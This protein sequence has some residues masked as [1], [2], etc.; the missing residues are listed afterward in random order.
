MQRKQGFTLI[1]LLVVISIIALLIG[2]LLP[3][4]G[5]ARRTA[6][7][8][9]NNT[10]L[11]GVHQGFVTFAQ[12]NKKGGND[13]F[14]PSLDSSGDVAGQE[15]A[16]AANDGYGGTRGTPSDVVAK[17]LNGNFFTPDYVVNP[18]DA[19]AE[20]VAADALVDD[21]N[22]SYAMLDLGTTGLDTGSNP[23]DDG[24]ALE[25]KETL[26]TASVIMA[27]LNS[28][29]DVG[30]SISSVWT[31]Q[32]SGEWRGGVVRNDNSTSF[33]TTVTFEQTK[34]GNAAANTTDHIFDGTQTV[35][36][37]GDSNASLITSSANVTSNHR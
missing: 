28:G 18:A 36:V 27:D 35:P 23:A 32:D 17:M 12:S 6:R 15:D 34:Y 11:R 13:G 30:G 4:L 16:G 3:A 10:Q 1:E 25:W 29:N 7:Q 33:E 5:A 22:F 2:I 21:E 26:N 8:M 37:A 14:F 9:A 24:R 19:N 31:E 20:E